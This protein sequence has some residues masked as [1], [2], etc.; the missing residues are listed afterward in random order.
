MLRL[1]N[2][3][4]LIGLP[5]AIQGHS[6]IDGFFNEQDAKRMFAEDA[7]TLI[8]GGDRVKHEHYATGYGRN[9]PTRA[10]SNINTA[11]TCKILNDDY[12]SNTPV[13]CNLEGVNQQTSAGAYKQELKMLKAHPGERIYFAYMPNG[14]V[15]KDKEGRGS[16]MRI[17]WSGSSA[18]IGAVENLTKEK[19]ITPDLD[20]DDGQCGETCSTPGHSD[21]CTNYSNRKG[22]YKPCYNSFVVPDAA[23][24]VYPMAWV[25]DFRQSN[26]VKQTALHNGYYGALYSTCFDIEILPAKQG[27]NAKAV[28]VAAPVGAEPEPVGAE[29]APAKPITEAPSAVPP[30][31]SPTGGNGIPSTGPVPDANGAV[32]PEAY[33][34]TA[35]EAYGT[36]APNLYETMA[37]VVI[38]K[39][40]TLPPLLI[41]P[42]V[43]EQ[44]QK[45]GTTRQTDQTL[46]EAETTSSSKGLSSTVIGSIGVVGGLFAVGLIA[47]L[48]TRSRY[49]KKQHAQ[50]LEHL[51]QLESARVYE[52]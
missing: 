38:E 9:Y 4:L 16:P 19:A 28:A 2:L 26:P 40:T 5:I 31:P 42:N 36:S 33:G 22:D 27:K 1:R 39:P 32:A 14:H 50:H 47:T 8:M 46:R 25:W 10:A 49:N 6:W 11:Y 51:E 52:L 48:V 35:P 13:C 43:Q 18:E 17:Y 24:G 45:N 29:P 7:A 41:L 3:I 12:R 20:F 30:T 23:P 34:T 44:K 37:P 21:K 15:S